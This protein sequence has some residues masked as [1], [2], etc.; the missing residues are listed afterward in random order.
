[1]GPDARCALLTIRRS[2]LRRSIAFL[3]TASAAAL[4]A[5][6]IASA[7]SQDTASAAPTSG[8]NRAFT[9]E[10]LFSLAGATDPQISPDGT[11]VAYVRMT[12]DVMTDK[13]VPTIWLVEL[14][15]GRQT[16]LVAGKGSHRSP[17]WSPDGKRLAY[18]SSDGDGAPQL[19]VMW[20]DSGRSVKVTGMPDSPGSLAWSPDGRSIAYTMRVPGEPLK[21]GKAPHKP[22]GAQ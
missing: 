15:S 18:V 1:M 21:L 17:M 4:L 8:P 10:D 9:G 14:A 19:N 22:E 7:Q 13:E 2:D 16:P 6:P 12:A 3:I 5:V 20:L 11:R